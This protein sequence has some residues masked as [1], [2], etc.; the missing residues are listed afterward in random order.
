AVQGRTNTAGAWMRWS[1]EPY[2]ARIVSTTAPA[3]FYLPTSLWVACN[4]IAFVHWTKGSGP[5]ALGTDEVFSSLPSLAKLGHNTQA[6][7]PHH[8]PYK[9]VPMP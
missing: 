6:P 4:P 8:L 5:P 2:R 9:D 7:A 1:G 3:L